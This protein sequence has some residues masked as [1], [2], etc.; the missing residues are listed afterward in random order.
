MGILYW[1]SASQ[2][3]CVYSGLLERCET[4][5]RR[6]GFPGVALMQCLTARCYFT[7]NIFF[8]LEKLPAW[9]L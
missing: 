8:T 1:V 9:N 5:G 6:R 2:R 7:S 4:A 3:L